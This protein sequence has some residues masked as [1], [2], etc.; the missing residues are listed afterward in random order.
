MRRCLAGD[1][2]AFTPLVERY[3][4]PLYSVA[5]RMLGDADD[6]KDAAQDAFVKAY[7]N[8]RSFDAN[9]RFF[10][11]L[12][13]ILVNECLNVRRA[14]RPREPIPD[15]LASPD[16]AVAAFEDAEQRRQLQQAIVALPMEYRQ[17]I[18]LRHFTELSYDAIAEAL[19]I[20]PALVKSRLHS[21][22]RRLAEVLDARGA[23]R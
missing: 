10:S 4:R 13:R 12:Y 19:G 18:V 8:L 20:A 6:A 21:A 1:T 2:A 14:R 3:Q 22:R 5:Y 7:A 17:V 11:W 16:T 23:R 15:D 9:R